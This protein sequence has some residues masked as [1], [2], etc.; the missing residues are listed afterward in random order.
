M[1]GMA[2]CP[3]AAQAALKLA[4]P[5]DKSSVGQYESASAINRCDRGGTNLSRNTAIGTHLPVNN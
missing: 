2:G 5:P 3:A 4:W 1:F